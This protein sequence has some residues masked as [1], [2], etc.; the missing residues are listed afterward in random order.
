MNAHN[1]I[2]TIGYKIS[3]DP[4]QPGM[5]LWVGPHGDASDISFH[6]EDEAI[7]DAQRHAGGTASSEDRWYANLA[8]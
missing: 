8:E 2:Q 5:W 3:E 6:S 1:S 4:D 7:A